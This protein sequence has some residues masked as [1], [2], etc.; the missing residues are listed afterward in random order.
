MNILTPLLQRATRSFIFS[1]KQSK[2]ECFVVEKGP[3]G[4]E[5]NKLNRRTTAALLWRRSLSW[6]KLFRKEGNGGL[7]IRAELISPKLETF[8]KR[9]RE[10]N[11]D[12]NLKLARSK[13][14]VILYIHIYI[15][16]YRYITT[17]SI[18]DDT[19]TSTGGTN[20]LINALVD[21]LQ[22]SEQTNTSSVLDHFKLSPLS[23]SNS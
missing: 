1:L 4:N 9:S 2:T 18:P 20:S 8:T 10:A 3:L 16:M 22:G 6:Q 7:R 23:L 19:K 15:Y 11:N 12:D 5:A 14:I 17:R 13:C 21:V